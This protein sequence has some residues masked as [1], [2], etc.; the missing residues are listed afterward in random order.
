MAEGAI[1]V[2]IGAGSGMGLAVAEAI[3][4]ERPLL[5]ADLDV[6]A[7]EALARR[8]PH[9]TAAG[10]DV[11]D[12]TAVAELAGQVPM[13]GALV[14]TAGLSPTM[15][16]GRRIVEVNI[17]GMARV[18]SAFEPAVGPGSVAVCFASLAAH[19]V[20]PLPDELLAVL[21]D[22]LGPDYVDRLLAAGLPVDDPGAAYALSKHAVLRAVRARSGAWGAR[23]GRILSV[24]PGII[25]TPMGRQEYSR[26][27]A[28]PGMVV[29]SPLG[30][31]G[32]AEEVAAVVAFL[33]SDAAS[34]MTGSDVLV[35]GGAAVDPPALT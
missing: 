9:A 30:R 1:D 31:Q 32:T 28:M 23:G 11:T 8:L 33:C 17:V 14:V 10:C 21:D 20:P 3:A 34:F 16:P 4:G 27:P 19:A 29:G 18:L 24:S 5:L 22:P 6:A 25:D 2:V 15:A 26:Q 7:V 12:A 13:L 35:D